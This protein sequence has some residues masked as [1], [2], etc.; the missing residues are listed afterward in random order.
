[1]TKTLSFAVRTWRDPQAGATQ[2]QVLRVDRPEEVRLI[3][4]SFLVRVTIDQHRL[5]ERCTIRH[6]ASGREAFVQGGPGL[7]AFVQ[8]CLLENAVPPESGADEEGQQEQE[9]K[10]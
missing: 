9:G 2:L 3:N 6:V 1:M 4:S 7:S 5:T 10:L 8:V